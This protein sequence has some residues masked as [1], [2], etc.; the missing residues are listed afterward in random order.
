M[1]FLHCLYE[2]AVMPPA[3]PASPDCL[4]VRA[5]Q[6]APAFEN[7]QEESVVWKRVAKPCQG[8]NAPKKHYFA[9]EVAVDDVDSGTQSSGFAQRWAAAPAA[10]KLAWREIGRFCCAAASDGGAQVVGCR[11]SV[12]EGEISISR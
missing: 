7:W 5:P 4:I 1:C 9:G 3:R 12:V 6:A 8:H 11:A 10:F 2:I